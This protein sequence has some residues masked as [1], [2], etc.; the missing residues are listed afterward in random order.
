MGNLFRPRP[1]SNVSMTDFNPEPIQLKNPRTAAVLA[2]LVPGL[3]HLYQGRM[4]KGLLF[5]V[6]LVPM[7]VFGF[8]VGGGKVVYASPLPLAPNPASFI[9]DR[10]PF[11]CQAGIGAAAIPALWERSQYRTGGAP[12]F[13]GTFYPPRTGA[14]AA[15]GPKI[16]SHDTAGNEVSHPDELAKWQYDYGFFFEL[17]TIYTAIA[18]LL[19]VLVVYDAHS[20]PLH[21]SEKEK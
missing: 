8:Y 9:M 1:L 12:S 18:G 7:F 6:C 16:T 11:L 2:W 4:A 17:G 20:G 14:A 10:W 19:N 15:R 13:G 5:M 3:G 21:V